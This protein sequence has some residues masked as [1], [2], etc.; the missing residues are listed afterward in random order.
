MSDGVKKGR[1]ERGRAEFLSHIDEH[2]KQ[3]YELEVFA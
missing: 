1:V 3:L 2:I